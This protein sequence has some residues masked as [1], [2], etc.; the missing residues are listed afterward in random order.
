M[1]RITTSEEILSTL[2]P[3]PH[4]QSRDEIKQFVLNKLSHRGINLVI[5]RSDTLKVVF[6]CKNLHRKANT[7]RIP[8]NNVDLLLDGKR[9]RQRSLPEDSCPFRLRVSYSVKTKDW[10]IKVIRDEHD[11][12]L[13]GNF[14]DPTNTLL[15]PNS[16]TSTPINIQSNNSNNSNNNEI[17]KRRKLKEVYDTPMDNYNSP[18]EDD[19][20]FNFE[21]TKQI[22]IGNLD[23]ASMDSLQEYDDSHNN[24]HN[25][26]SNNNN[27]YHN[28]HHM[29]PYSYAHANFHHHHHVHHHSQNHNHSIANTLNDE[30]NSLM[31]NQLPVSNMSSLQFDTINSPINQPLQ[32][33]LISEFDESLFTS[34]SQIQPSGPELNP[35]S[36]QQNSIII[37]P[38][39]APVALKSQLNSTSIQDQLLIDDEVF[40]IFFKNSIISSKSSPMDVL[41]NTNQS[42]KIEII[43]S[44]NKEEFLMESLDIFGDEKFFDG[45]IQL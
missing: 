13:C 3:V 36:N 26:N 39:P 9:K 6:K 18:P 37:S 19:L 22:N 32:T 7:P 31:P 4:F 45:M 33:Q 17:S 25:N 40:N 41:Y 42:E 43:E 29:Q 28:D 12:N 20:N 21:D 44:N 2:S 5:E 14:G 11:P 23:I 34:S 30:L 35:N 24:L 10:S 27:N 1:N 15:T 38:P 8:I 16:S